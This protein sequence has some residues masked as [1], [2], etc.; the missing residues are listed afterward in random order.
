MQTTEKPH[1]KFSNL[2]A[3]FQ[4]HTDEQAGPGY[5]FNSGD[6]DKYFAYLHGFLLPGND[7]KAQATQKPLACPVKTFDH[8]MRIDLC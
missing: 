4:I 2:Q 5:C 8:Y 7:K 6:E 3:I 1:A